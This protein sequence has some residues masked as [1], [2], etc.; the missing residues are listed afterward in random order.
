MEQTRLVIIGAGSMGTKH[1]QLVDAHPCC[2]LAGICD[3]DPDRKVVADRFGVPFTTSVDTLIEKV[4]PAGAIIATPT[5]RH[6]PVAKTCTEHSV[7]SWHP[8]RARLRG[9]MKRQPR[10]IRPFSMP[11]RPA[12]TSLVPRGRWHSRRWSCGATPMVRLRAGGTGW[13][14]SASRWSRTS[15]CGLN[16]GISAAL[17]RQWRNRSW[18]QRAALGPLPSLLRSMNRLERECLSARR[19][20]S[21]GSRLGRGATVGY[22]RGDCSA[23][24]SPASRACLKPG[25]GRRDVVL[26]LETE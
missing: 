20:Y 4:H 5:S 15:H 24:F 26:D 16:W 23:D 10:R 13:C 21:W 11:M 19:V 8:T 14:G 9:L 25:F 6:E 3:A 17:L 18:M 2:L 1:A 22:A 12:T 7:R